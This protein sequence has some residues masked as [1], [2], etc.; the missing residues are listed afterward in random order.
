MKRSTRIF[1]FLLAIVLLLAFYGTIPPQVSSQERGTSI[2]NLL[3]EAE[4][5]YRAHRY[6]EALQRYEQ[7]LKTSPPE[8]QGQHAWL[9]TA[10]IYGIRGDW[11][12]ARLRYERLLTVKTDSGIAFRARYGVGQANYKLGNYQEAERI[13]ENLS[14]S[15][16]PGELRFKTN[17]LLTEISLQSGN[18]AQAFSRLLLLEKDLPF[19]EEE[20]FQDLKIRLLTR[21]NA[22]DL[23][24]LANLYRDTSLTAGVLLQLAKVELQAGRPE[25]AA[26]WLT[27]MQQRFP[28]SPEA[29][30]AKQLMPT[31]DKSKAPPLP[32]TVGCLLPLS[33]E[34]A[35][36]GRQVKNGLELAASQS[37]VALI[38]KDYGNDSQR[39][40]AT[41]EA[42]A[43]NPQVLVLM[44]FFPSAQADAAAAAAQRLEI[45]LLALTLRKDITLGRTSV[46]RDF[47]TQRLMLQALLNYTANTLGWQRY[48]ILY[49]NSKYG[50]SLARQFSEETNRQAARLVG[51]VSY[52]DGGRDVA[53]AVQ[54][55]SQINPGAEGL[56]SLDAVFIPDEANLVAAV[57]KAIASTPLAHVRVLGTNILHTPTTLEYG[58]VLSGILFPD[59]FFAADS[60]PAVKAFVADYRQRFQ[61]PPNYLAAQ[62]Y[63]SMRLLAETLN[64]FPGL[65]RGEFAQK[66]RHQTPPPGFSLFKGF[67]VDRE[68]ELTTKILTIR[69]KEFQLEH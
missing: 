12:Q 27:T 1:S 59:G 54:T 44:G 18:T 40:A 49:P 35:D 31:L 41:V 4:N 66:L 62:G 19:G 3:R 21:A 7:F 25:K 26:T 37:G 13:L 63:S 15:S 48:A 51:Q 43:N 29:A 20:W 11:N 60:D 50:Q 57:A 9:R 45:P 6:E 68:A 17:A 8:Q 55:L 64:N 42:L 32:T 36:V 2:P 10:E 53:Q 16:L 61:Q 38:I 47:L 23:E 33:G 46:F 65:T 24:K 22:L 30:Q 69:D 34:N 14:T 56:P 28:E 58:E 67:N 52:S 39:T 5:L